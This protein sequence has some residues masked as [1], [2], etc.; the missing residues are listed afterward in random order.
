PRF[1]VIH[2]VLLTGVGALWLAITQPWGT[3]VA[4]APIYIQQFSIPRISGSAGNVGPLALQT[5][6]GI[7]V[8]AVIMGVGLLL[9]NLLYALLHKLLHRLRLSGL[10]AVLFI[11]LFGLLVVLLLTDLTLAAGFGGLSI[12]SQLPFVRDH[13]FASVGAAHAAL[14]FYLWWIG[15]GVTLIGT[16]GEIFIDRG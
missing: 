3:D 1:H 12:V 4:G 5:A 10:A 7:A 13:G 14:G 15:I 9:V 2:V 16:L 6:T 8:A 11:P